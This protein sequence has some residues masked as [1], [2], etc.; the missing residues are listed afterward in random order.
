[1]SR[2]LAAIALAVACPF[3]AVI[4]INGCTDARRSEPLVGG[5]VHLTEQ[6]Q[7]GQ[8]VFAQH[9]YQCHPNGAAGL[10]PAI[11][12]KPL[13]QAMI[14]TQVR[15]GA[16]AMPGFDEH[17]IPQDQLDAVASYLTALRKARG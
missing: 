9:C 12:N 6:Q 4:F 2:P 5:P 17:H 11:N 3:A 15:V 10:G 7:L 14:K 8:Q 16:G 1:M 13:P